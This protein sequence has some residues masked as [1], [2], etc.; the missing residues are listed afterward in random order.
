MIVCV[1]VHGDHK[2]LRDG[3]SELRI[4]HRPGYRI[5]Y[6][7]ERAYLVILLCGGSKSSQSKD[8]QTAVAYWQAYQKENPDADQTL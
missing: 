4:P 7:K 3:V 8:I 2:Y 5:Y 6:A 1:W